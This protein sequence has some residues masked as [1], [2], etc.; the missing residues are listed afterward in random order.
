[1]DRPVLKPVVRA[2]LVHT[3]S[4]FMLDFV[5]V[6]QCGRGLLRNTAATPFSGMSQ[7]IFELNLSFR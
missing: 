2:N 6:W 7:P 4:P 1:M 3:P 5:G